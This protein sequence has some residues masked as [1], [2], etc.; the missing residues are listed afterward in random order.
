M[1]NQSYRSSIR[2]EVT[3]KETF[4]MEVEK[5]FSKRRIPKIYKFTIWNS[6]NVT[7]I[8]HSSSYNLL[9]TSISRTA[10]ALQRSYP[11]ANSWS[12]SGKETYLL[13]VD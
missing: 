8:H 2:W 3:W 11:D 4:K 6:Y 12:A 10:K 9:Y 13:R 1:N 5:N 7:I